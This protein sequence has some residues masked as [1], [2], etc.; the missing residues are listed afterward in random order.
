MLRSTCR[1]RASS[2]AAIGGADRYRCRMRQAAACTAS[3]PWSGE[4]SHAPARRPAA[5]R[6]LGGVRRA[7]GPDLVIVVDDD[8][9]SATADVEYALATRMEASRDYPVARRARPRFIARRPDGI[10]TKLGIGL[11]PFGEGSFARC[12][13]EKVTVDPKNLSADPDVIR[14]R[15]NIDDVATRGLDLCSC[16][17]TR[18]RDD[19]SAGSRP[20]NDAA[21]R[22]ALG[23]SVGGRS[24]RYPDAV[25]PRATP[26]SSREIEQAREHH[27]EDQHRI[28]THRFGREGPQRD[29]TKT[30]TRMPTV[31]YWGSEYSAI[32]A[33]DP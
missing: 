7:Q 8:I 12:K 31:A 29:R 23:Y 2:G 10:R 17:R 18:S 14:A 24:L 20:G 4:K 3:T 1:R 32:L 30:P 9:A 13:F 25:Q 16:H 27:E 11:A 5:Q 6:H 15:L 19:R 28:H 33:S 26:S 22:F 21:A